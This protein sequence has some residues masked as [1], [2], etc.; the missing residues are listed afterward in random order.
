MKSENIIHA[1]NGIDPELIADAEETRKKSL[2]DFILKWGAAAACFC[3]LLSIVLLAALF[4]GSPAIPAYHSAVY[5]ASDI[6]NFFGYNLDSVSTNAYT[7]VY[8]PSSDHLRIHAIPDSKYL[9]IYQYTIPDDRLSK[10]EFARF[11]DAIIPRIADELGEAVPV[12]SIEQESIA[13]NHDSLKISIYK[14]GKYHLH[15][16]QNSICNYISFAS[17]SADSMRDIYLGDVRISVDQ[18]QSDEQIAASLSDVQE[19][20]FSVFGVQFSNIR[21]LRRY[22]TYSEHGVS[23]L[24]VY[25]YNEADHPM[26]AIVDEP[27]SDYISLRFDNTEN[28]SGDVVSDTVLSDVDVTYR[29]LRIDVDKIFAAAKQVKRISLADAEALLH[30]GYVFGGHSCPLCMAQQNK[31]DFSD[32]DFVGIVYIRESDASDGTADVIPFYAFYKKIGTAKNGNEIYAQTFVPAIAVSGYEEHF[33]NQQAEHD[34]RNEII[35]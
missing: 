27:V 10:S 32:Y 4:N 20:L 9:T 8:V 3:M 18:T 1:L 35:D 26:N 23:S 7:T 22:N 28:W 15:A 19:K 14:M 16:W 2:R 33:K 24:S 17:P 13:Y 6:A 25:F 12:Y 5:T 21:I 30:K 11:I 31:V 29:Q 34:T